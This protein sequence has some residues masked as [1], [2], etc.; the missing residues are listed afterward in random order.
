MKHLGQVYKP[1]PH[2]R[3]A[4]T[5]VWN[6]PDRTIHRRIVRSGEI[7]RRRSSKTPTRELGGLG[8]APGQQLA[9]QQVS[10]RQEKTA[11]SP[12]WHQ[13]AV[14]VTRPK[15][16]LAKAKE[17]N[18]ANGRH[19]S[20]AKPAMAKAGTPLMQSGRQKV[21]HRSHGHQEST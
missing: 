4:C 8:F 19:S 5:K 15:L 16:H 12:S 11:T 17:R 10:S 6:S 13:V 2:S 14:E 7:L 9:G 21:A 18:N 20:R 3:A 1:Q